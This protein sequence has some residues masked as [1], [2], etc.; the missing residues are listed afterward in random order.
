MISLGLIAELIVHLRRRTNL[1]ASMQV[2]EL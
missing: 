2:D 1:D